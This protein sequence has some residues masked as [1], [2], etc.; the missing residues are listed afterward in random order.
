MKIAFLSSL[1][2][3]LVVASAYTGYYFGRVDGLSQATESDDVAVAAKPKSEVHQYQRN[4]KPKVLSPK[5]QRKATISWQP[6]NTTSNTKIYNP[7]SFPKTKSYSDTYAKNTVEKI[8]Q[9]IK[10]IQYSKKQI[11]RVNNQNRNHSASRIATSKFIKE[12]TVVCRW[13][14]GRI[15]KLKE[16]IRIGG[17]G[18]KSQFC[19]EYEQRINEMFKFACLNRKRSYFG[20]VC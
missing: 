4:K 1:I 6:L 20:G 7:S 11:E 18:S 15:G 10:S 13:T 5:R 3:L 17:R 14:L 19:K 2:L 16:T 8:N 12:K 9:Q